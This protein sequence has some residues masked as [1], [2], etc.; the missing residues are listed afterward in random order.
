[1]RSYR[2]GDLH[3]RN[4]SSHSSGDGK[5]EG[6]GATWSGSK[7]PLPGLQVATFSL[8]PHLTEASGG[9]SFSYKKPVLSDQDSAF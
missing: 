1:V 7:D 6:K 5:S 8:R 3:N 9:S 4:L 2:I